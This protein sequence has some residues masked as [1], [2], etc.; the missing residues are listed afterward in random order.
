MQKSFTVLKH[1]KL[2]KINVH[3]K[4]ASFYNW[5]SCTFRKLG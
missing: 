3:H 1:S 2:P 5:V 4:T